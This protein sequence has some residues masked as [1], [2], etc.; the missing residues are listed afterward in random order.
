MYR[1]WRAPY[2]TL[3]R[4]TRVDPVAGPGPYTV[5]R[6]SGF[7]AQSTKRAG[8]PIRRWIVAERVLLPQL[9]GNLQNRRVDQIA[10]ALVRGLQVPAASPARLG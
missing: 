1:R 3:S 7:D 6:D 9:R 8:A 4:R 10:A 5:L 2:R